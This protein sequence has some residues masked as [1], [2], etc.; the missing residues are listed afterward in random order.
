[1]EE[2]N[3]YPHVLPP[4]MWQHIVN[5]LKAEELLRTGSHLM[6]VAASHQADTSRM[7]EFAD[8]VMSALQ[9]AENTL[10]QSQDHMDDVRR[11][12]EKT[13]DDLQ[14]FR[15]F[16]D[17]PPAVGIDRIEIRLER[18]SQN[19]RSIRVEHG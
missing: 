13:V 11:T 18:L 1:M 15:R 16:G 10:M 4:E 9:Y 17:R 7:L 8:E 2:E 6:Q 14:L 19:M 3:L 5:Y 12:M